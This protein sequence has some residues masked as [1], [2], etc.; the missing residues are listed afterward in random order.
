MLFFVVIKSFKFHGC[1]HLIGNDAAM[2]TGKWLDVA[3][4]FQSHS[5]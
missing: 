4:Q 1:M 2:I 3:V 5:P